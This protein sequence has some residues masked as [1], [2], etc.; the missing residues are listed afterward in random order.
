MN[1]GPLLR[2][3]YVVARDHPEIYAS[4]RA[5]FADSSRLGIVMDRRGDPS[6]AEAG[7][8]TD[9][10]QLLVEESLRSRGWARVRIEAGGRAV[11]A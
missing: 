11:L 5:N 4:L 7:H 3:L 6:P 1:V 2:V 9:R 10:R 8:A